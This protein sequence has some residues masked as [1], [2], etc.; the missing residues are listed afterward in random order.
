MIGAGA[1]DLMTA[2]GLGSRR[3]AR[4][5]PRGEGRCG[6]RIHPLPIGKFE[7]PAEGGAKFVHGAALVTRALMCE[8][9]IGATEGRVREIGAGSSLNLQLYRSGAREV[10]A[11]EPDPSLLRMAESFLAVLSEG[12]AKPI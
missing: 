9:V 8:R 12:T 7:Y 6:G 1:A 3:Q 4:D 11:L 2:R 10:A 5:H